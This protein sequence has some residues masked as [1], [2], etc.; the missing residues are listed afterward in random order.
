M[1]P[2]RVSRRSTLDPTKCCVR[3]G[4]TC[5]A[6]RRRVEEFRQMT[7]LQQDEFISAPHPLDML[8][9]AVEDNGWAYE[10]A[11]RDELNLSVAG[12]WCDHHFSFTWREDLQS[13]HLSS[14]FDMRIAE[15]TRRSE[16]AAL[17]MH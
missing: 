5:F 7:V 17:L 9:R 10:R 8:E 2:P 4:P 16:V 1:Q 15:G 12:R 14:G 6:L 13:L 3:L 11:G